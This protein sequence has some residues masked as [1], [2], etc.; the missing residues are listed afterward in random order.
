MVSWRP[1][2]ESTWHENVLSMYKMYQVYQDIEKLYEI[3]RDTPDTFVA[4][5][6]ALLWQE[7][8]I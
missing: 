5:L 8:G 7:K 3:L 6:N 1:W 4:R 2:P